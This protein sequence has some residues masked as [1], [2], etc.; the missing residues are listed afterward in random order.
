MAIASRRADQGVGTTDM[1]LIFRAHYDAV[2]R[3]CL[4]R[5]GSKSDAE[6]A[7]QEVF[8]RAVSHRDELVGDALPWLLRTATN[9][10]ADTHRRRATHPNETELDA[11]QSSASGSHDPERLVVGR[12]TLS[13][14]LSC[15][16]TTERKVVVEKWLLDGTHRSTGTSMGVSAGTTKKLLSRAKQR[17]VAYMEE[18]NRLVGS[19]IF[20]AL[21]N[22]PWRLRAG[23]RAASDGTILSEQLT[24]MAVPAMVA[25]ALAL[26]LGG[27]DLA[28]SRAGGAVAGAATS[29]SAA[30][31][32]APLVALVSAP[33]M[34]ISSGATKQSI[35]P[36]SSDIIGP[37]LSPDPPV[38]QQDVT[39]TDI[40]ASPNYSSDH[41]IL[42]TGTING[43]V[44]K[45]CDVLFKTYDD[46][47]TWTKLGGNGLTGNQ[48]LLPA[49]TFGSGRFYAFGS[50][51]LEVTTNDG[52][53]F[54]PLASYA[55]GYAAAA[56][57]W[58]SGLVAVSN[59]D[60]WDFGPQ[61]T[62]ATG[63]PTLDGAFPAGYRAVGP[64]V[65]T[66]NQRTFQAALGPTQS[67]SVTQVL[68]CLQTC[69][70]PVNLPWSGPAT[71]SVS[72][73]FSFDGLIAAMVRGMIAVSHDGGI[74]YQASSLPETSLVYDHVFAETPGSV[75][76][77][78][79]TG[80]TPGGSA[81]TIKYS[82][83]QGRTWA[84]AALVGLPPTTLLD[85]VR[86]VSPTLLIASI[87]RGDPQAP[88]G[89]V[90][91]R[92]NGLTWRDCSAG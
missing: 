23:R 7:V 83:D 77:V 89:F 33:P 58:R 38:R 18:Q 66:D 44:R 32:G 28:G 9:L 68:S 13:D 60:I 36:A 39:T 56:P 1:E 46:G 5:L 12:M 21:G 29:P 72:P 57:S 84:T 24:S 27:G 22:L 52:T 20:T 45:Q 76:L 92:D 6:D 81:D 87:T 34:T 69:G 65:F 55:V 43:C 82:D 15:L 19:L 14:M 37:L 53:D 91:S 73:S 78:V 25:A 47:A 30:G 80:T 42:A 17:L 49:S 74:T 41:E 4:C 61:T 3:V 40:A 90:C 62:P 70:S 16:T 88:N 2:F 51:G 79:L 8:Y 64:P 75:R 67:I 35:P 26:S 86:R 31:S 48:L 11:E 71:L 10:C 54:T 85:H 59:A 50:N 63:L